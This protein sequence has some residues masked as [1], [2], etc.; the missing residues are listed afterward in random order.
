MEA[1]RFIAKYVSQDPDSSQIG[2][3]V[4]LH[5]AIEVH[6]ERNVPCQNEPV[7]GR[8]DIQS[9]RELTALRYLHNLNIAHAEIAQA[10]GIALNTA[11]PLLGHGTRKWHSSVSVLAS[12][13][14]H[15]RSRGQIPGKHR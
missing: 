3:P 7:H 9:F 13:A 6:A 4:K 12:G 11:H 2:D 8:D 1:V 14:R 5:G 10:V 15:A